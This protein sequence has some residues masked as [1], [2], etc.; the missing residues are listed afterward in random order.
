METETQKWMWDM[1]QKDFDPSPHKNM[2]FFAEL[3]KGIP[4]PLPPVWTN[5]PFS[6]IFLSHPLVN[7]LENLDIQKPESMT[8]HSWPLF[9]NMQNR[10]GE[11]ESVP[12]VTK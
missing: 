10:G 11:I 1:W 6:A 3:K 2:S 12:T 9:R 4:P 5:V 7:V 8:Q